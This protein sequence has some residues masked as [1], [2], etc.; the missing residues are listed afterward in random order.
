MRGDPVAK[1]AF[2]AQNC[3]FKIELS[4][5]MKINHHLNHVIAFPRLCLDP[6]SLFQAIQSSIKP[7]RACHKQSSPSGLLRTSIRPFITSLQLLRACLKPIKACLEPITACLEP[8]R[9]YLK[10]LRA[11]ETLF[12]A[13]LSALQTYLGAFRACLDPRER[14][15]HGFLASSP[16]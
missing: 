3:I 8:I 16:M 11:Q 5:I 1:S 13:Y 4:G 7:L 10:P 15:C 6:Q 9:A 2:F 14:V 12:Q